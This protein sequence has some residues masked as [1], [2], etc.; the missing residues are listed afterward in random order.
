MYLLSNR[1]ATFHVLRF[2]NPA[3]ADVT[4]LFPISNLRLCLAP[5]RYSHSAPSW[6]W[7]LHDFSNILAVVDKLF[8]VIPHTTNNAV[9]KLNFF[10]KSLIRRFA[11]KLN[12]LV[13]VHY[14]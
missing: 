10:F 2:S 5:N 12:D 6:A 11:L 13:D 8:T 9:A 4:N 14:R 7:M 3:S 1:P